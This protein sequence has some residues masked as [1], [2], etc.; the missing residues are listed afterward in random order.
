MQYL[1]WLALAPC[2]LQIELRQSSFLESLD[3][4]HFEP[5]FGIEL[6]MEGAAYAVSFPDGRYQSLAWVNGSPQY[7]ELMHRW[8]RLCSGAVT[9]EST[10]SIVEQSYPNL[11]WGHIASV[12]QDWRDWLD[13]SSLT[14]L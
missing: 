9:L 4:D 5:V 10:T 14:W 13:G 11:A 7:S 12:N 1:L 6:A 8:Y 2:T 3:P